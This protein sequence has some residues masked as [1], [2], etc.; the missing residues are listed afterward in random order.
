MLQHLI[1]L[2]WN[3]K[4]SHLL[5]IIEIWASFM[6][7]FGVMSL[8]T[9]NLDNYR[10]PLG[11][12]YEQVWAIDLSRNQDTV[13]TA[14]KITQVLQK[15]KSYPEVE[16]V[17]QMS[18][19]SPFSFSQMNS[20][21]SRKKTSTLSDIYYADENFD[22]VFD[23][24]MKSGRWYQASDSV[25]K[26]KPIVINQ[27]TADAL[28]GTE[29]PIGKTLD[30]NKIVVGVIDNFKAK[31]EFTK[32]EP[33]FFQLMW[34]HSEEGKIVMKLKS[35]TDANFEA[36][37]VKDLGNMLV[38]W[39]VE[40]SYLTD[41]RQNQHNMALVPM[42]VF[43]IIAGFLLLN[44]AMGLFGILKVNIAKRREEI[45]VRRAMGATE[46][47]I[48]KQFVAEMWVI[49]TFAVLIGLLFAVQ[50]PILKVFD[51]ASGVYWVAIVLAI[52]IIYG[53]V[54]ICAFYPSRQAAKI[55]PAIVLHES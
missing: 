30:D 22:D 39:T 28:F 33:A 19:N 29:N 20:S 42:I 23:I 47:D 14:E 43:S 26:N 34:P 31:G 35:G 50:F 8:V 36:K 7:L 46:A 21:I 41:Q 18:S 24:K 17:S 40:V 25:A 1:K 6:V 9:F 2:I 44:V 13:Q 38:G 11:F 16:K 53:L 27:K 5:L 37:L 52:L 48:Q 10:E 51:L 3:R 4:G 32:N 55:Q 12:E 49:A 45:G 15:I 54:T